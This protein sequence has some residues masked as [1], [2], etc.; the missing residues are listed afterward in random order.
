MEQ[1]FI[2]Q[3]LDGLDGLKEEWTVIGQSDNINYV[4]K[5]AEG[6]AKV[7]KAD[8][9]KIK[10]DAGIGGMQFILKKEGRKYLHEIFK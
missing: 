2:Y 8:S 1:Y 5:L 9:G 7:I 10:Y 6:F 3:K 4:D